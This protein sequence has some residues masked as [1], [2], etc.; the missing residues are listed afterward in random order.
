MPSVHAAPRSSI[1]VTETFGDFE[2]DSVDSSDE[3]SSNGSNDD[4]S[5]LI[6]PLA[7]KLAFIKLAPNDCTAYYAFLTD[8]DENEPVAKQYSVPTSPRGSPRNSAPGSADSSPQPTAG[9]LKINAVTRKVRNSSIGASGARGSAGSGTDDS[10]RESE[11]ILFA[12][13]VHWI[14]DNE[15]KIQKILSAL[16]SS[17]GAVIPSTAAVTEVIVKLQNAREPD[18][19]K[20]RDDLKSMINQT[21]E[22]RRYE[23]SVRSGHLRRW[24]T[25]GSKDIMSGGYT[26]RLLWNQMQT[27]PLWGRVCQLSV[28]D[29]VVALRPQDKAKAAGFGSGEAPV[30]EFNTNASNRNNVI[31]L[32]HQK[33]D[34]ELRSSDLKE[35]I[36][37]VRSV[38][39]SDDSAELA[40]LAKQQLA[41]DAFR[42]QNWRLMLGCGP[43][44][45]RRRMER[46]FSEIM[47]VSGMV[48]SVSSA[49][50]TPVVA[51]SPMSPNDGFARVDSHES[52]AS[53]RT[54]IPTSSSHDALPL[55]N[56]KMDMDGLRHNMEDFLKKIV[57]TGVIR[58]EASVAQ[59]NADLV[60]LHYDNEVEGD[61]EDGDGHT[62]TATESALNLML[63]P[64]PPPRPTP[65]RGSS[66]TNIDV[67]TPA[68]A[69]RAGLLRG[70]SEAAIA[71]DAASVT[72]P[73]AV[74]VDT[75]NA[76]VG[77][78][79]VVDLDMEPTE[80]EEEED[81][82]DPDLS[83]TSGAG[84]AAVQH[85]TSTEEDSAATRA[86]LLQ[87]IVVGI[88]GR[89]EWQDGYAVNVSRLN[90]LAV[91]TSLLIITP[92]AVHLLK[93]FQV[94]VV[95]S[96]K[97]TQRMLEW[98]MSDDKKQFIDEQ[99]EPTQWHRKNNSGQQQSTTVGGSRVSRDCFPTGSDKEESRLLE[100]VYQTLLS[101]DTAYS[102]IPLDEIFIIYR[103]RYQLKDTG[104]EI[105][106]RHG[107][108]FLFACGGADKGTSSYGAVGLAERILKKLIFELHL[109]NS[110][111]HKYVSSAFTNFQLQAEGV[112][113]GGYNRN[114]EHFY[115]HIMA[116]YLIQ[117]TKAW[118]KGEISNFEYLMHLNYSAG[119]S[120]HDLT[121]YP[122]FPWVLSDYSSDVLDLN[123]PKVFR[124]LSKPMGALGEKRLVQFVERY[125]TMEEFVKEEEQAARAAKLRMQAP[126]GDEEEEDDWDD[127]S[128]STNTPPPFYYG[129][130]YSCSGYVLYYLLRM[131][132]YA[133]AGIEL[134][135]GHFDVADR[136]F[137]SIE[138]S[139][140][141][142][143]RENLQD[144]RE[145][146]PEFFCLPDFLQNSNGY[147][148][149][150]TQKDDKVDNVVLPRWAHNDPIEFISKHREALESQ[151]I[152]EHLNEW[153]DLIFGSK[154]RGKEAV[155]SYNVFIH[156]TYPG[157]VDIDQID[158]PVL[159][160]ATIA[161]IDNFGQ[162][163]I[164]LFQKAHPKRIVPDLY[165]SSN[166]V[167]SSS[168]SIRAHGGDMASVGVRDRRLSAGAG[169]VSGPSGI[170][171]KNLQRDTGV[172]LD[173]VSAQ[174]HSHLQSP[175][176]ALGANSSQLVRVSYEQ[177]QYPPNCGNMIDLG[178][179]DMK[180]Y[181]GRERI[182]SV[183]MNCCIIPPLYR[184]FIKLSQRNGTG[185]GIHSTHIVQRE[186]TDVGHSSMYEMLHSKAITCVT[187]SADGCYVVTGSLDMSV[188]LW[189]F[190]AQKANTGVSTG[191]AST[192]ISS[193]SS[194]VASKDQVK[195]LS[196]KV[197]CC[198][199]VTYC[200]VVY[201]QLTDRFFVFLFFSL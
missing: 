137:M 23:E 73:P 122:V 43:E 149:G 22:V 86:N 44:M 49:A 19:V 76:P 11:E 123:N 109:P 119:R 13:F 196:L 160:A 27:M 121:Q 173:P 183:P 51:V 20:A 115:N 112:V 91:D 189:K 81:I 95:V 56:K 168:A 191:V 162:T 200:I 153:I 113:V 157:E 105:K 77:A 93:G 72:P 10:F 169:L 180:V 12:D 40:V 142:A 54:P 103:H 124:D 70:Y 159:R 111:Y 194:A 156:L 29:Q 117:A 179:G 140:A 21:N 90:G 154:Q 125:S 24:M 193:S 171:T 186:S 136:L 100:E 116:Q 143:S 3:T 199:C 158:D 32:N 104:L 176:C 131:Q 36:A 79:I 59:D 181:N 75:P 98:T 141:S 64:V 6:H 34:D 31:I 14:Y 166:M 55:S 82:L 120:Y 26:W 7:F 50:V 132:P 170:D 133:S 195:E 145:L 57:K 17:L 9:R 152:S 78:E 61:E 163:P 97:G 135:G 108:S 185:L 161:Q 80:E 130:H 175:L 67:D 106:D 102:V 147:E 42:E 2:D 197:S 45:M 182:V 167:G 66:S 33:M 74:A 89:S 84:G 46:N 101:S 201:C 63:T 41:A 94:R 62:D 192:L 39:F 126:A 114:F 138:S 1:V 139:W 83:T 129:T 184:K 128:G 198:C 38:V 8:K 52:L 53:A 4:E 155:N 25:L 187:A 164:K 151:Y 110:I 92:K 18:V 87:E 190:E 107:N 65:V 30:L 134:Q 188:R 118:Q 58:K 35:A 178:V 71:P 144:V 47:D 177:A 88:V 172:V 69:G 165:K 148:F 68:T 127:F 16:D 174:W 5:D 28:A 60:A 85:L 15:P 37:V 99:N 146:I 96:K 150:Y 48:A